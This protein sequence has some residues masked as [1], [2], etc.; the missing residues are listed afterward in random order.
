MPARLIKIKYITLRVEKVARLITALQPHFVR[1]GPSS[2][3]KE[4]FVSCL[5]WPNSWIDQYATWYGGRPR[6]RR[7]CVRWGPSSPTERGTA[8]PTFR[9]SLLRHARSPVS[10]AAEH[11]YSLHI[12]Y[13]DNPVDGLI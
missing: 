11:L 12:V 9:P 4:F 10:A 2:P 3:Q 13:A 1:R 7:R 6:P 5:L 8:A